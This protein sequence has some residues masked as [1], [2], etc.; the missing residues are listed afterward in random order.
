MVQH[1]MGTSIEIATIEHLELNKSIQN[2]V[3]G[4]NNS[5]VWK[6]TS[7]VCSTQYASFSTF[8]LVALVLIVITFITVFGNLLVLVA[9]YRFKK[10]RSMSNC[11][12]GNLAVSD[13]LL[14]LSVLPI[15]VTND[16]LGYWVFGKIMCTIW[17]CIDVLYCTASIWGLCTI[18]VDRYT[19][20]VY[21][22]WYLEKK[23]PTRALV[24]IIFVWLFSII[25]SIAPFIGW[26]DM[27]QNFYMY[28]PFTNKQQ[29][30]LFFS[31]SYVVYSAM[32][33][34]V[35]PTFLM[36]FLYVRIFNVLRKRTRS[37]QPMK[38]RVMFPSESDFESEAQAAEDADSEE[39][40]DVELKVASTQT[41][42][43]NLPCKH[44]DGTRPKTANGHG[45]H[46]TESN[47]VPNNQLLTRS[48]APDSNSNSVHYNGTDLKIEVTDFTENDIYS[49]NSISKPR[50][51][52]NSSLLKAKNCN[53]QVTYDHKKFA[54]GKSPSHV[55]RKSI[56]FNEESS[57]VE[58]HPRYL[59]SPRTS[60]AMFFP[61]NRGASGN[62]SVKHKYELRERRATKRMAMI[63]ACFCFCW[64]PFL[65]M[66]T[67]RS[68]CKACP[69]DPHFQAAIIWLGY[70]NSSLNP[71][72]YTIFNDDF[73]KAFKKI[74]LC[75]TKRRN[76]RHT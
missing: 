30:V 36:V 18:A 70:A 67:I 14:A 65:L 76:R 4:S 37:M 22:V 6:L 47:A 42:P 27:I 49:N 68:F 71:I 69:I 13:L 44:V 25:V 5:D 75:K 23:S 12:I 3:C 57:E 60:K 15:S 32:G 19:A 34:F 54:N 26:R 74:V 35:I 10:L 66:Y 21:P 2:D 9:L 11:L 46:V 33:S 55:S 39:K 40:T 29:C 41:T 1:T 62:I 16:L 28:D 73:R 72:L 48:I 43:R 58:P 8:F 63:M 38:K 31:N 45:K 61:W 53:L 56:T 59:R 52:S 64:W 51:E 7:P 17:L 24:Y 50:K 20:T